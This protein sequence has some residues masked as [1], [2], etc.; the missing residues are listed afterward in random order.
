VTIVAKIHARPGRIDWETLQ[1]EETDQI[2]SIPCDPELG[3]MFELRLTRPPSLEGRRAVLVIPPE[4]LGG[5]L[6]AVKAAMIAQRSKA[7]TP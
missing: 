2:D 7:M 6:K 1:R 4:H 3:V 5:V